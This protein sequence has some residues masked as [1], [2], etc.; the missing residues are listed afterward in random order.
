M[1]QEIK[2]SY[3]IS[4]STDDAQVPDV[5]PQKVEYTIDGACCLDELLGHFHR[6]VKAMG[7]FPPHNSELAFVSTEQTDEF[8]CDQNAPET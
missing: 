3:E 2:L 7:Y 5:S 6:F 8:G 1:K 4:Y